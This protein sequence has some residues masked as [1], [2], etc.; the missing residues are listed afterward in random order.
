MGFAAGDAFALRRLGV[1]V[2]LMP[3]ERGNMNVNRSFES[4]AAGPRAGAGLAVVSGSRRAA[5]SRR[6]PTWSVA[7]DGTG[8]FKTC[9][10]PSWQ[11]PP[12]ALPILLSYASSP[13]RKGTGLRAREK[14]FFHLV[15]K[16]PE[17]GADIN[18]NANWRPRRQTDRTYRTASTEIDADD[19]TAENL[20]FENSAGPVGQA[21]AIR[22]DGDRVVFRN[23]RFLGWQDTILANRGRHYYEG[24][25]SRAHVDFI[26]GAATGSSRSATS[27][28]CGDGYITAASTPRGPAV[29]LRL[30]ELEI[31]GECPGCEPTWGGRGGV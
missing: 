31:T 30:L 14:R 27:S 13:A 6:K 5:A 23:C 1:T 15:G 20:T 16:T 2:P 10:K 11:C 9:R 25:T 24:C 28:A 17:D 29:R 19:F 7:A 8:Q 22:V 18:L 21:L 26:F 3:N 12:A 4:Y